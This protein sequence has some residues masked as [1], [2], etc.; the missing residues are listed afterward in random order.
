LAFSESDDDA[1]IEYVFIILMGVF[2]T[3]L[4]NRMSESPKK[5]KLT[6]VQK[7]KFAEMAKSIVPIDKK[8]R[9]HV[10]V[11]ISKYVFI[12]LLLVVLCLFCFC[13]VPG[14][15]KPG[16]KPKVV[17]KKASDEQSDGDIFKYVFLSLIEYSIFWLMIHSGPHQLSRL[18]QPAKSVGGLL[19][20]MIRMTVN[21]CLVLRKI[22]LKSI[23]RPRFCVPCLF[24][25]FYALMLTRFQC[26]GRGNQ[27]L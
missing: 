21:P 14:N 17:D 26:I 1:D 6:P 27:R 12:S 18:S 25:C 16:I 23:R 19:S 10:K 22:V 3:H 4:F 13:F 8:L 20:N 5:K 7:V 11:V 2:M 24:V 15:S 9:N